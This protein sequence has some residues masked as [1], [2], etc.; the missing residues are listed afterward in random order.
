MAAVKSNADPAAPRVEGGKTPAARRVAAWLR[1]RLARRAPLGAGRVRVSL[2]AALPTDDTFELRPM[3]DETPGVELAAGT[4]VGLYAAAGSLLR[5]GLPKRRRRSSPRMPVRGIYFAAHFDVCYTRWGKS[6][7]RE[8]LEEL[9]SW[10]MNT[11]WVWFDTRDYHVPWAR[12]FERRYPRE[13][14]QF[15]RLRDAL[16]VARDLG[17]APALLSV[18][19]AG[20]RDQVGKAIRAT[21]MPR[22]TGDLTLTEICPS[23]PEG[24]KR[25]LENYRRLLGM[26]GP[27]A[28]MTFWPLDPGGCGCER[29]APW[30]GGGFLSIVRD[31]IPVVRDAAPGAAT[32]I[33][34][35]YAEAE[36][37]KRLAA[38]LRKGVPGLDGVV[39]A[40]DHWSDPF[41]CYS[42]RRVGPRMRE[43]EA[44]LPKSMTLGLFPDL[45]M[46]FHLRPNG[47]KLSDWGLTGANPLPGRLIQTLRAAPRASV[48]VPYSEGVF[49]DF[50]KAAVLSAAWDP[51][52]TAPEVSRR[53]ASAFLPSAPRETLADLV[54]LM[55]R[56]G[57]HWPTAEDAAKMTDL[58]GTIEAALSPEDARAWRWRILRERVIIDQAVADALASPDARDD[59]F[60]RIRATASRLRRAYGETLERRPTLGGDGMARRLLDFTLAPDR[61]PDDMDPDEVV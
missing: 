37:E 20:Y 48:L 31:L 19:N 49:D 42:S 61:R 29:C 6:K 50:N 7:W 30:V 1:K 12:G 3:R 41:P 25:I 16:G 39:E 57:A 54:R 26:L 13:A 22:F 35:T 58:A 28:A 45:S 55:E 60:E 27:F 56:N 11:I 52:I 15:N 51:K 44:M 8:A 23:S 59:A 10:G 17:I 24:R 38:A 2:D 46:A 21:P 5:E 43:V 34:N 36:D 33:S 18:P 40:W 14:R 4:P 47:R 32:Y 53:Y 9:A